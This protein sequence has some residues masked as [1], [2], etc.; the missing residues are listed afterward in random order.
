VIEVIRSG[1]IKNLK[2]AEVPEF[3]ERSARICRKCM[4]YIKITEFQY[5]RATGNPA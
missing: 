3:A 2:A 4:I 5:E 1:K